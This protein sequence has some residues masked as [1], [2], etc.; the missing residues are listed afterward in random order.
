MCLKNSRYDNIR[1]LGTNSSAL[2]ISTRTI[3]DF[4]GLNFQSVNL[5]DIVYIDQVS[6][7]TIMIVLMIS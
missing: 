4:G 3:A 7:V 2:P 1:G 6:G 5:S